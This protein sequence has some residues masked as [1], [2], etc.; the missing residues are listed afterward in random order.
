MR[1]QFMGLLYD[2]KFVN[3]TNPE[4]GKVCSVCRLISKYIQDFFLEMVQYHKYVKS[5]SL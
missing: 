2:N 5:W 1:K 4:A 3:T